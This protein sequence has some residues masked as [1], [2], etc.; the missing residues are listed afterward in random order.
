MEFTVCSI[1]VASPFS[2]P[3]RCRASL[4]PLPSTKGQLARF[5]FL[6]YDAAAVESAH[7]R[8]KRAA[9][10]EG[11]TVSLDFVSHGRRF[12]LDLQRDHE[13]LRG[14]GGFIPETN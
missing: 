9:P 6:N 1:H 8:H 14:G 13:A 2:N 5:E 3:P 10:E 4:S 11:H 7:Q 12:R